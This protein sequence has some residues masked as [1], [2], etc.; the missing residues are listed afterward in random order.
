M[1]NLSPMM[2]QY[3]RIK[4]EN[5]EPLLFFRVGD[6]Y[7]M[8]FDDA[9]TGSREL[10]LTLTGKDCGLPERAP[11][12]GVP[13]HAVDVYVTRLV[14]KGYKVAICEQMEDP[15]TAK[16]LVKRDIIRIITPG[17]LTDSAVI[18]EKRNNYLLS[19]C[20]NGKKAG[21]AYA[22]VSTG[23]MF[24]RMGTS[25][26]RDLRGVI[27]SVGPAEIITNAPEALRDFAAVP[28]SACAAERFR[29]KDAKE[30]L[31]SHFETASLEALGF[32]AANQ[33][34]MCAAGALMAYLNDTQKNALGHITRIQFVTAGHTMPL[35]QNTIRN[36]ELTQ[37][38]RGQGGKG[39]LL[40]V[41][42]HTVTAMG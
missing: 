27:A 31:L 39:T 26:E 5:P 34:A 19:V 15:S 1:P 6:F 12:C 7:E 11:M 24:A 16:G 21:C 32:G 10:E 25:D 41:I 37:T 9:L 29:P 38:L 42:D 28:V 4:Q 18:G 33:P 3:L 14:E 2:Q 30:R 22:D 36:L 17:T 20:I 35:D 13:F 8:F 23:E 40:S